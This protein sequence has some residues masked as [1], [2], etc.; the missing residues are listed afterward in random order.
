MRS[1][2][3]MLNAGFSATTKVFVFADK[4][5]SSAVN[6][7]EAGEATT[8]NY[9]DEVIL[10]ARAQQK[11]LAESYGIDISEFRKEIEAERA[12]Y[13]ARLESK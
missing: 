3:T 6:I 13:Y 4:T 11:A 9:R 8:A 5:M 12:T 1:F 7:A 10:N 2:F